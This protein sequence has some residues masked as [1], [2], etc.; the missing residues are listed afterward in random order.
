M[1]RWQFDPALWPYIPS[2]NRR[3]MS[4][5]FLT[6]LF[7]DQTGIV[8]APAKYPNYFK[9]FF[10]EWPQERDKLE[11]HLDDYGHRDV[12]LSPALFSEAR[13]SPETF[14][15]TRY[16]WSEFDG[17]IPKDAIEPTIR[18]SSSGNGHEHWYWKLDNFVTDT[19]LL[20]DLTRRIAYHYGADL[21]VWDYQN[22]LRPVDT[23]NHKR[24]KPVTLISKNDQSMP[25]ILSFFCL[26][27][28]LV[29]RLRLFS[30]NSHVEIVFSQST[31]GLLTLMICFSKTKYLRDHVLM[32]WHV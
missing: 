27:L 31:N 9:Q 13:I 20:E 11:R 30:E 16:L 17:T 12:Y 23:W 3:F 8:Y 24:N 4:N 6:D 10:F 26:F 2:K 21:S 19:V 18:V 14:K 1:R 25:W 28:L 29:P 5:E 7:G 22:V 15:G 32:L